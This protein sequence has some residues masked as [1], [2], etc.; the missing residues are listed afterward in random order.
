M[1][2]LRQDT[3]IYFPCLVQYESLTFAIHFNMSFTPNDKGTASRAL[4][5]PRADRREALAQTRLSVIYLKI[6]KKVR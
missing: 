5:T 3:I 2:M 1:K 6:R 4:S